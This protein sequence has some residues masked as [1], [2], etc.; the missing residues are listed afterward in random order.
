MPGCTLNSAPLL[1]FSL[2]PSP[3]NA[4]FVVFMAGLFVMLSAFFLAAVQIIVTAGAV[5]VLFLFI[6]MLLDLTAMEHMPR[7]KV[8]MGLTFVL[9]IGFLVIVAKVRAGTQE[10]FA[11]QKSLPIGYDMTAP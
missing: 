6:I 7:Q 10:G 5:M 3:T 8:W 2:Y 4:L 9:A 1:P 11:T